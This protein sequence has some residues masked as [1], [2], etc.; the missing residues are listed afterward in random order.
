MDL[1]FVA[2]R[3]RAGRAAG[4]HPDGHRRRDQSAQRGRAGPAGARALRPGPAGAAPMSLKC[5]RPQWVSGL[6]VP[7]RCHAIRLK[8]NGTLDML[9]CVTM[10]LICQRS[11]RL[12]ALTMCL[13]SVGG[14]AAISEQEHLPWTAAWVLAGAGSRAACAGSSAARA[15]CVRAAA[16]A[17]PAGRQGRPR[18]RRHDRH[19]LAPA[20]LPQLERS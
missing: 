14:T 20:C 8:P 4:G 17:R 15:R 9:V 12:R 13:A 7:P 18:E 3:E 1:G 2:G 11:Q 19:L 6:Q 5:T 10:S 16:G